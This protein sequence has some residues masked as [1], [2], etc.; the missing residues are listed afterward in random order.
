MRNTDK[1]AG[2]STKNNNFLSTGRSSKTNTKNVGNSLNTE[3]YSTVAGTNL[4]PSIS[5]LS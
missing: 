1:L 3:D 4:A 5:S 2:P